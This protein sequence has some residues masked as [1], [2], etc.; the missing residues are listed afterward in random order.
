M[1]PKSDTAFLKAF[2]NLIGV[3]GGF[4][5]NPKDDGNWTGGKQGSGML[6]GTK[7]GIAASSYPHLDIPNLTL[8]QA[9]EVY[10][11]DFWMPCK[12]DK[13]PFPIA[14]ALFDCAVNSGVKTAAKL[15]QRACGIAEDGVIGEITLKIAS[16]ED[17]LIAFLTA[18]AMFYARLAKFELFGKGWMKRLFIVHQQSVTA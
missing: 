15:L 16:K 17:T 1:P 8:E 7:Y 5:D 10:Y 14:N 2:T 18:R 11:K 4:T 13:L 12:A 9:Q 3:E 6:K